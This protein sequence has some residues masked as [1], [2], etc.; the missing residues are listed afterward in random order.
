MRTEYPPLTT[1]HITIDA[2]N[3][4]DDNIEYVL[5]QING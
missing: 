1:S 3:A 2:I 4:R 5:N